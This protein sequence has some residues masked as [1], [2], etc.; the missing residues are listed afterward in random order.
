[1]VEDM[2][3]SMEVAEALLGMAAR[4]VAAG[5]DGTKENRAEKVP[6]VGKR[7]EERIGVMDAMLSPGNAS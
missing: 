1:M 6:E 2:E 5:Q 4:V 3:D 7:C